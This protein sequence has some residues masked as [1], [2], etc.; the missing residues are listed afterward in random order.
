M[1]VVVIVMGL[2]VASSGYRGLGQLRFKNAKRLFDII[3]VT[4][5]SSGFVHVIPPTSRWMPTLSPPDARWRAA[6]ISHSRR[7]FDATARRGRRPRTHDARAHRS[8]GCSFSPAPSQEVLE[9]LNAFAT[10]DGAASEHG[11]SRGVEVGAIA[12]NGTRLENGAIKPR[13]R[14]LVLVASGNEIARGRVRVTNM[15]HV[16]AFVGEIVCCCSH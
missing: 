10:P 9:P 1:Q 8:C 16:C 3:A 6:R 15:F 4:G 14:T 5:R 7:R 12:C 2:R 13:Q 11:R